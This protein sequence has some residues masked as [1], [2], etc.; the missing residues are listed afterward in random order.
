MTARG[1]EVE[2]QQPTSVARADSAPRV[3]RHQTVLASAKGLAGEAARAEIVEPHEV[4]ARIE[5]LDQEEP[6]AVHRDRLD[7]E[8]AAQSHLGDKPGADEVDERNPRDLSAPPRE[9]RPAACRRDGGQCPQISHVERAE[10]PSRRNDVAGEDSA[11]VAGA[12]VGRDVERAVGRHA[13]RRQ[14]EHHRSGPGV[15][16]DD[17]AG[18]AAGLDEEELGAGRARALAAARQRAAVP[19]GGRGRDE[20]DEED[21]DGQRSTHVAAP[22]SL[23][24]LRPAAH[25]GSR[26][27]KSGARH[28]TW[29]KGAAA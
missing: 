16:G 10:Q 6:V 19:V 1:V 25:E 7:L 22:F 15:V 21:E 2:R 28:G 26:E 14:G 3:A 23:L 18:G 11:A 29:L 5:M 9:G 27:D 12:R 8:V 17:A 13:P 20:E 4:A 24:V